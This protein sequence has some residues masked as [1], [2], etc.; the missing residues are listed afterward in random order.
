M[1]EIYQATAAKLKPPKNTRENKTT[2]I[3]THTPSKPR[4]IEKNV[5]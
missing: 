5:I 3:R 4:G 2:K 1:N